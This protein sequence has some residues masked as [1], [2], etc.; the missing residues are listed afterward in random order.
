LNLRLP[1]FQRSEWY[2]ATTLAER[3]ELLHTEQEI[4]SES[5]LA[6]RRMRRWRSQSPFNVDSYFAQ[7]LAIDGITEDEFRRL[8]GIPVQALHRRHP[9]EPTWLAELAQAYSQSS[10]SDVVPPL[11]EAL[12]SREITGFL[13]VVEP[14]ISE[15][16]DRLHKG[17]QALIKNRSALPFN[18]ATVAALLLNSLS[19]QLLWMMSRTLVLE[20]NVARLNGTLEGDTPKKRFESFLGALRRPDTAIAMLLEYPVLARQVMIYIKNWVTF[21]LE[22]LHHLCTDWQE[23]RTAFGLDNDPG[24]L[25]SLDSGLGDRH[26]RGRS[27]LRAR[28]SFDFQVLYKPRPLAVEAHFQELLGWLND[29]GNRPPFQMLKILDRGSYGWVQFVSRTSCTSPDEVSRFFERQ[30]GYLALL[31]VLE[32]ADF[33]HENLIAAGEHPVLLDL[34]TLFH[35]RIGSMEGQ[36][37]LSTQFA[38]D[39]MDYSVLRVGMLPERIWSNADSEGIDISGIGAAAG[40]LSPDR[41]PQWEDA[42][43]DIMRFTRKRVRIPGSNNRP[44]LNGVEVDVLNHREAVVAG[45]ANTYELLLKH[46]DELLSSEGPLTRFTEDE[47]RVIIRPTR[48]Y[49]KMLLDSFHPDMLRNALD[50]DCFFDRLW[51]GIEDSPHLAKTI[52]GEREDLWNGDIP[53]FTTR[54]GSRDLWSS[55]KDRIPD[56]FSE[57]AMAGVHRRVAR[58]SEHDLEKQRWFV[59]AA[60]TTLSTAPS[61]PSRPICR[62]TEPRGEADGEDFLAAARAIGDRLE[63]LALRGDKGI[64]WIGLT[65]RDERY[66]SLTP[67]GADLYSGLPGVALFLAY[68]GFI[69][70]EDRYTAMARAALST[71]QYLTNKDEPHPESIGAFS[72]WGGVIYTLSHLGVLWNE[73]DLLAE[74]EGIVELLPGLIER[75]EALD[76]IE[77]SAGCIGSL[78]TLYACAPSKATLAAATRCGECLITC[79]QPMESGVGWSNKLT[80]P[81]AGF[82][83]GAAGIAWALLNLS[84]LTGEERFRTTAMS[85]VAYERSLFSSKAGN[86]VDLRQSETSAEVGKNS[87]ET[88]MTAWCHGAPGIGLARIRS[89]RYLDD[90]EVRAEIDMALKTTLAHGF[91][92]NHSL[93]HGDLGNLELLLQASQTFDDSQWKTIVDARAVA[94]LED[95]QKQ[96]YLCGVPLGVETPGL[97]TGLAGI[98]YGLLRLMEPSRV[99]SVLVLE[100]HLGARAQEPAWTVKDRFPRSYRRGS[101]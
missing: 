36:E 41:V 44:L 18:P 32:A 101:Y 25:V 21:S 70:R 79:A 64:S 28:F 49:A 55:T 24:V 19:A 42:G 16:C 5:K 6:T 68:L 29:R 51:V 35:P 45:F 17:V 75:D 9:I 69:S 31:Y 30:G 100:P 38:S 12:R 52:R 94:I 73:S 84:A 85:A 50:R 3:L 88:F 58:L 8:L 7:R 60:L 91:G 72:G 97:M 62:P 61:H 2:H 89:L 77:G 46:R 27:V 26:R 43:T 20:L 83:H 99:P 90:A 95:I 63:A 4:E 37:S 74:A 93:C 23:I 34:E 65:P 71:L 39:A 22:F 86:W 78:I 66:W 13:N 40:Q 1:Q 48:T 15:G 87:Q 53:I 54:P 57:S 47:V 59:M 92:D 80:T 81:L 11:P 76:I 33:H 96:G 14:L 82:A 10:S 56:F 98:G 67:L